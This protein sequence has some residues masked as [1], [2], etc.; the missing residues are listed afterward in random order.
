MHVYV[1]NIIMQCIVFNF[2]LFILFIF[3]I[4]DVKFLAIPMIPLLY[5]MINTVS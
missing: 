4:E 3:L 1:S 5:R 2:E